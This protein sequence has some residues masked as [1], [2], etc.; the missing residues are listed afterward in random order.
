[1]TKAR[2]RPQFKKTF[3]L[4]F[5]DESK[6][7]I[8]IENYVHFLESRK[9]FFDISFEI[10]FISGYGKAIM[11]SKKLL[12]AYISLC[13][14]M[15]MNSEKHLDILYMYSRSETID[16]EILAAWRQ[17][18][19]D[20]RM[21]SHKEIKAQISSGDK[22]IKEKKDKEILKNPN[23]AI[24]K[25]L[26]KAQLIKPVQWKN[27][28]LKED[29]IFSKIRLHLTQQYKKSENLYERN[30]LMGK[31][32]FTYAEYALYIEQCKR[33]AEHMKVLNRS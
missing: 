18:F 26:K 32:L 28:A 4:L 12:R 21:T 22:T 6:H 9:E 31:I 14:S 17:K 11:Y 33:H 24:R 25:F 8:L 13:S 5:S 7:D 19:L 10:S 3:D 27:K 29:K 20:K 30:K 15:K 2:N 23:R 1:L 16:K